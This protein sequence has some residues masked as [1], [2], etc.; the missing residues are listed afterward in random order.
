MTYAFWRYLRLVMIL[1]ALVASTAASA[2]TAPSAAN[3][4]GARF[5]VYFDEFSAFLSN[6]AKTIIADAAKRARET[7]AHRVVVQ[8][9]ASATGTA[10]TNRYLA[11]T[12]SSIVTDQLE[13][14][15]IARAI[16]QQEPIGQTG[17]NDP[18]V[19]ERRVDIILEP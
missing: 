5:L 17:S 16:I 19:T 6:E 1:A 11:Q 8:A 13:A 10:E 15:G 12:R 4:G 3:Q 7:G 14:D 2:Q 9:R 18:T